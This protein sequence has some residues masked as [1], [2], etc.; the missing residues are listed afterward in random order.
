[1]KLNKFAVL[2]LLLLLALSAAS[3]RADVV[4]YRLKQTGKFI[5][6]SNEIALHVGGVIILDPD[7]K[8]GY[9]LSTVAIRGAKFF[10]TANF[11]NTRI[12]TV[13]GAKGKTYTVFASSFLSEGRDKNQ[14][15]RGQNAPLAIKSDRTIIFPRVIAGSGATVFF[16]DPGSDAVLLEGKATATFSL[17]DTR[18]ANGNGE[19]VDQ[20]YQRIR[21]SLLAQG[22]E[23]PPAL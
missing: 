2:A 5:G 23:E 15:S 6:G 20:V 4:I 22:Y 13:V 21:E 1:M 3:A 11:T 17:P 10:T 9:T 12:Y 18:T 14:I 8:Q 7:T 19:T 16:S